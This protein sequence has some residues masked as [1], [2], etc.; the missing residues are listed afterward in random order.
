MAVTDGPTTVTGRVGSAF[1]S[2][3]IAIGFV[4]GSRFMI[5][6]VADSRAH[7]GGYWL[8]FVVLGTLVGLLVPAVAMIALRLRQKNVSGAL[9]AID[10]LALI[11]GFVAFEKHAIAPGSLI[12]LAFAAMTATSIVLATAGMLVLIALFLRRLLTGRG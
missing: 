2:V 9:F 12:E 6:R 8:S 3:V 1:F 4:A 10:G 5:L 11:I 7:F